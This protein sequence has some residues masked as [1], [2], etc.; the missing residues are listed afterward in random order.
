MKAEA[1]PII[2][3]VRPPYISRTISSRPRPPSAP[4][5]NLP[6]ASNHCGPIGLPSTVTTSRTS[7]ST[8][9]FSSVWVVFGPVWATSWDHSGAARTKSDDQEEE[10]EEGQR[11][12]VAPQPPVGQVPGAAALD[13]DPARRRGKAFVR[14]LRRGE[15]D[16]AGARAPSSAPLLEFEAGQDLPEGRVEDD[17]VEVDRA[18]DEGR[19]ASGCRRAPRAPVPCIPC[20]VRRIRLPDRARAV[21]R[22]AWRFFRSAP[23]RRFRRSCRCWSAGCFPRPAAAGRSRSGAGSPGTSPTSRCRGRGSTG[24]RSP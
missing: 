23:G 13:R 14:L 2:S 22:R 9:S 11:G 18:G 7:P 1:K 12:A 4:R 24:C 15:P 21:L 17:V 3:E 19:D 20:R 16:R 8:C 10:A 6:P 5:K